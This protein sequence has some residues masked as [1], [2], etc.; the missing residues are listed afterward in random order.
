[1]K[2]MISK[3]MFHLF[4]RRSHFNC[5]ASRVVVGVFHWQISNVNPEQTVPDL[6]KGVSN[7]PVDDAA[8]FINLNTHAHNLNDFGEN[9]SAIM[10][11]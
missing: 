4:S 3:F 11:G 9:S 6:E 10:R 2:N 8:Q 5:M 1:M 7:G